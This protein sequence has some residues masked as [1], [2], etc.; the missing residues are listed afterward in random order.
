VT[1]RSRARRRARRRSSASAGAT[2]RS[3]GVAK[4]VSRKPR[5]LAG[6][7]RGMRGTAKEV[8]ARGEIWN[9]GFA[10][11][12]STSSE[13]D[14]DTCPTRYN[15]IIWFLNKTKRTDYNFI[16]PAFPFQSQRGSLAGAPKQQTKLPW[17]AL[18][19]PCSCGEQAWARRKRKPTADGQGQAVRYY[20][21]S[22]LV[23]AHIKLL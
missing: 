7:G 10:T 20:R 14:Y 1:G 22:P 2:A 5:T 13:C 12:L 18:P 4:C 17:R 21:K 19:R 9:S 23:A 15:K 11:L 16:Y 6:G 3:S 8:G